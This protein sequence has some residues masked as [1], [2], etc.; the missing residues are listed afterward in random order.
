M[1]F[2]ASLSYLSKCL[3]PPVLELKLPYQKESF[4]EWFAKEISWVFPPP[5]YLVFSHIVELSIAI[6][7]L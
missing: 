3:S 2:Q 7:I 5:F 1:D 6:S 4:Q